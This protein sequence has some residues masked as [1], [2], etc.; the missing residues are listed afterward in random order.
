MVNIFRIFY[1]ILKVNNS[2]IQSNN[3]Y[4][5]SVYLRGFTIAEV[6]ITIGIVGI[7]ATLTIPVLMQNSNSKKFTNQ[8]KKSLSTLNQSAISA[9]AQYDMDYFLLTKTSDD[10]TCKNETLSG[11]AYSL[12]GLFNDTLVAQTYLGKYGTVK[13]AD[14]T[15][16]YSATVTS[17]NIDNFLFFA[18]ADGAIVAFNP[19]AQRC[20]IGVGNVLS[21]DMIIGGQ[22]SNCLG[23]V[24]VNGPTPPNREVLCADEPTTLSVNTTCKVTNASMGD[25]FPIVFYD[26]T[27]EP[28]TNAATSVFLGGNW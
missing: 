5:A 2:E 14:N 4:T 25:I 20:G 3:K 13:A 27:V 24:D 26:G 12:C 1:N 11:N 6:L 16:V 17:L 22:L 21:V 15:S 23:F 7:V 28:V 8:F 10:S 18:F 19:N 9:L